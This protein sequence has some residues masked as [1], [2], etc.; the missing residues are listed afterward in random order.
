MSTA[1]SAVV[2][3]PLSITSDMFKAGTS[4]PVVDSARGEVAWSST[5]AYTGTEIN[6]NY[7]RSLYAAVAPSTNVKPGTDTTKWRRTGPSNRMAAF[8]EEDADLLEKTRANGELKLVMQLGQFFTGIYLDGMEG[9]RLQVDIYEEPAGALLESLDVELFEQAA[10]LWELLFTPLRQRTKHLMRNLPLYPDAEVHITITSGGD[11]PCALGM[12]LIG[13]WMTLLGTGE[14]GGVEYGA[15]AGVKSNSSFI[16]G[17]DGKVRR[18]RR[19]SSTDVSCTVV[20][21]TDEANR[22]VGILHQAQGRVVAWVASGLS[23]YD[24]L[25]G[26]G[27]LSGSATPDS[28]VHTRLNLNFQGVVQQ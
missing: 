7:E 10:G 15:T 21:P 5:T 18:I 25:S 4:V 19:G 11:G 1:T 17:P 8:S 22:A 14:W 26:V 16:R 9:E 27:D 2:L 3:I 12:G 13:H 6:I 20:I 28:Y 24:F 23:R